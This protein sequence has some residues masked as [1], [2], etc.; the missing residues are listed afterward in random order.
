VAGATYSSDFPTANAYQ[1][2]PHGSQEV[3]ITKLN[4]AG[5]AL[6]YSTYLGGSGDDIA[7]GL[8]V[9]TGGE[10]FLTGATTSAN[11]P[12]ASPLQPSYGGGQ[13]AF[14]TALNSNGSGL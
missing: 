14:V 13:D 6:E 1:P 8:A 12:L 5:T 4:A 7:Y 11:F 10:A 9:D 2:A 3:F